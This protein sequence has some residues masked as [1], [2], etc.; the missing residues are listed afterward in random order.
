[1]SLFLWDELLIL[2]QSGD[3]RA[4]HDW[5]NHHWSQIVRGSVEADSDPFAQFLQGLAFSALAFHYAGEQNRESAG[6]FVNDGLEVLSR[7]PSSYAGIE[8]TPIIDALEE[9]RDLLPASGAEQPIPA[10]VSSVRALRFLSG[11]LV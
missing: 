5:I 3:F 8:T 6:L 7:Y 10:V 4:V 1:M 11:T 2:W 9:L